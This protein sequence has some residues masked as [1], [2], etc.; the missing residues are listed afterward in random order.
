MYLGD[1]YKS[2][3]L[4]IP[5]AECFVL[6]CSVVIEVV[7]ICNTSLKCSSDVRCG[8]KNMETLPSLEKTLN[9]SQGNNES[10]SCAHHWNIHY[11]GCHKTS[12][13]KKKVQFKS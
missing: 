4:A 8:P 2:Q 5:N 11:Y 12:L 1:I 9:E 6:P 7:L 13:K 3:F 10:S